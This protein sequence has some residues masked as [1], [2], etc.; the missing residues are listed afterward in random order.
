MNLNKLLKSELLLKCEELGL[1]KYKS[2]TK[3][4]LI[5]LIKDNNIKEI[6]EN[7]NNEIKNNEINE[8]N[9]IKNNEIN[10]NNILKDDDNY[11]EVLLKIRYTKYKQ[12]Y[13]STED[14]NKKYSL[15]LR[16]SNIPEDITE[17]IAKFII[18]KYDDD[19]NIVWCKGI[20]KF[21]LT[22]DLY[23]NKYDKN[24]QPEIKSFM[25]DGPISFGPNRNFG[26]L[27]FLDLRELL[28]NKL[29]LWKVNLTSNSNEF[30]NIKVNK[31]QT[32]NDQCKENR[33]PRISWNQ[34]HPQI[35]NFCKKI[36]EGTFEDIFK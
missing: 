19:P 8:N 30:K 7:K 6:N 21:N 4:E 33:R 3:A 32:H 1:T 20:K 11:D 17:N 2:K 31:N 34:L 28:N 5:N 15:K 14:C 13:I 9:E 24:Y 29:I 26:V 23:S 10:E 35:I 25:S 18:R 22:G 27:F 36:Y 12:F 16:Q